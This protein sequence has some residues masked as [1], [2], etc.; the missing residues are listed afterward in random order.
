MVQHADKANIAKNVAQQLE[1]QKRSVVAPFDFLTP[2]FRSC[3]RCAK[4]VRKGSGVDFGDRSGEIL[5]RL[6]N[7]AKFV[8]KWI[9]IMEFD[10]FGVVVG[11]FELKTGGNGSKWGQGPFGLGFGPI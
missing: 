3:V 6:G 5:G 7:V 11:P 2:A 10:L 9:G 8:K 4:L 1:G